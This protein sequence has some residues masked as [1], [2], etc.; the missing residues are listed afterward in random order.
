MASGCSK[1]IGLYGTAD[2]KQ[3]YLHCLGEHEKVREHSSS[4]AGNRC[5]QQAEQ[6]LTMVPSQRGTV[7][8]SVLKIPRKLHQLQQTVPRLRF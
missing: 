7:L 8:P 4:H 6:F 3:T 2:N 5:T 1:S